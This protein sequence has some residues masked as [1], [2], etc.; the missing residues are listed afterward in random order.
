MSQIKSSLFELELDSG[1]I[2][3]PGVGLA[4]QSVSRQKLHV[5]SVI[6]P[7]LCPAGSRRHGYAVALALRV[8]AHKLFGPVSDCALSGPM[9]GVPM[10][11]VA[12]VSLSR[13]FAH[14]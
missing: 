10:G 11:G 4:A 2:Y 6:I 13:L 5:S 1:R 14:S 7:V 9:C 8:P 3:G 12:V